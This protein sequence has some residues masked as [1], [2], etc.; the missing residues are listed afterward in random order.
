MNEYE[1][2]IVKANKLV[3]Y[4]ISEAEYTTFCSKR[5]LLESQLGWLL[6]VLLLKGSARFHRTV[7]AESL[8]Q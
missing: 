3:E 7:S 5:E 2:V 1:G 4:N 6:T 8:L